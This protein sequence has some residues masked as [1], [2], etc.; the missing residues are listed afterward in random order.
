[1]SMIF[2]YVGHLVMDLE[3][4]TNYISVEGFFY[5]PSA[6]TGGEVLGLLMKWCPRVYI[7]SM[8]KIWFQQFDHIVTVWYTHDSGKYFGAWLGFNL[9]L[10]KYIFPVA[11]QYQAISVVSSTQLY[12]QGASGASCVQVTSVISSA[13]SSFQDS[14]VLSS[15]KRAS[16]I[17]TPPSAS[18]CS[19][20]RS[21]S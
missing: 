6:V 3:S 13:V 17:L 15:A 16:G 19:P 21:N 14:S 5:H 10:F 11:Y 8:W 7:S 12:R 1:M 20:S 2:S 18:S 4:R 9:F